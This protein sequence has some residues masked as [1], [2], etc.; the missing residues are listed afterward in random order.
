MALSLPEVPPAGELRADPHAPAT[1]RPGRV[2]RRRGL[3]RHHRA[4]T[5][6]HQRLARRTRPTSTSTS[7]AP[8]R[9]PRPRSSCARW[10]CGPA[11]A[12]PDGRGPALPVCDRR[13]RDGPSAVSRPGH[14]PADELTRPA[15]RDPPT[16][17]P[18][19]LACAC[20]SQPAPWTS[21]LA[22]NDGRELGKFLAVAGDFLR[23]QA[24]E[25]TMLLSV[26]EYGRV[27]A[28]TVISR[29]P[30][31]CLHHRSLPD[32]R[33]LPHHRSRDARR[34]ARSRGH[35][36][37]GQH[38]FRLVVPG[39][40]ARAAAG[41]DTRPAVTGAFVHTAGRPLGAHVMS[42]AVAAGLAGGPGRYRSPRRRR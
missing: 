33:S 8:K 20:R 10:L 26:A 19:K 38:A 42:A 34:G 11:R 18:P 23:L 31:A 41:S 32:H 15:N 29:T 39:R 25:N 1:R 12:D 2:H 30:P 21:G 4:G 13:H 22:D 16:G 24:V 27:N 3:Q 36:R 17:D 9:P 6:V 14:Q 40:R 37:P 35:R 7:R 28:A 5:A